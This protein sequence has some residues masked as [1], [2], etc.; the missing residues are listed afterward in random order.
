MLNPHPLDPAVTAVGGEDGMICLWNVDTES[1]LFKHQ[2]TSVSV[3]GNDLP[4]PIVI[5]DAA[6]SPDGTRMSVTDSLG[7]LSVLG[8]DDPDRYRHVPAEQYFS[9]DYNDVM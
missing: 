3:P 2:F 7:R 1:L 8:L 9:T 5:Y 6:F 4:I